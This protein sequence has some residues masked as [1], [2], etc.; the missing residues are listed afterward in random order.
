MFREAETVDVAELPEVRAL[1]EALLHLRAFLQDADRVRVESCCITADLE[2]DLI[3][4]E[5]DAALALFEGE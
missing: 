3:A 5:T 2:F 1:V 4:R